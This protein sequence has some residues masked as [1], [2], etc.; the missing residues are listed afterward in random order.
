MKEIANDNLILKQ[1]KDNQ[2]KIQADTSGIYRKFTMVLKEK[3]VN[4]YTYQ[5]KKDSSYKIVIRRI[6]PRI[7]TNIITNELKKLNHLARQ[8][9]TKRNT[10]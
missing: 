1:L 6:H 10:K 9:R 7:D 4:F 2:V 5:L 8:I 3:N